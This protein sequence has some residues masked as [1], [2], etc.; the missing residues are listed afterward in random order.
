[1]WEFHEFFQTDY[2]TRHGVPM[3]W[4]WIIPLVLIAI[5]LAYL[6]GKAN[7]NQ[8]DRALMDHKDFLEAQLKLAR[9]QIAGEGKAIGDLKIKIN[10]LEKS[11]RAKSS[12]TVIEKLLKALQSSAGTLAIINRDT[13]HIVGAEDTDGLTLKGTQN[14][15]TKNKES[16]EGVSD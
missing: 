7:G 13:R 9:N 5:G 2:W 4:A 3:P 14:R 10:E 12:V 1:M 11:L 16:K 15:K 6:A 8:E